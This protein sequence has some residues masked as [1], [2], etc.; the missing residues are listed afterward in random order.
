VC[1]SDLS[2]YSR[3]TSANQFAVAW[4]RARAVGK[5]GGRYKVQKNSVRTAAEGVVTMAKVASLDWRQALPKWEMSA[6]SN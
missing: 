2:H 6:S 3:Q 4:F 5:P 1:S